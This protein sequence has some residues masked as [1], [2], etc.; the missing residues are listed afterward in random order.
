M[1]VSTIVLI[2]LGAA[3]LTWYSFRIL[4]LIWTEGAKGEVVSGGDAAMVFLRDIWK[5]IKLP[6]VAWKAFRKS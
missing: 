6:Y 4:K 2:A 5:V 3:Y 1:S